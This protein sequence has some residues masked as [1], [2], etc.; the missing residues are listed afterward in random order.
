MVDLSTFHLHLLR[1][2]DL[3]RYLDG[4]PLQTMMKDRYNMHQVHA[5]CG[6]QAYAH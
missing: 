5:E 4:Q 1:K 6:W 2:F 3:V